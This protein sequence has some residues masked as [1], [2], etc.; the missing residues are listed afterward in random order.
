MAVSV[1]TSPIILLRLPS[2]YPLCGYLFDLIHLD[3]VIL[4]QMLIK[5]KFTTALFS[6]CILWDG[7]L[8]PIGWESDNFDRT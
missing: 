2:K 1:V 7:S 8:L 4:K 6:S 5:R 3:C